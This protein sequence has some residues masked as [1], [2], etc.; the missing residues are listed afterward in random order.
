MSEGN[1]TNDLSFPISKAYGIVYGDGAR[2]VKTKR[3]DAY[4]YLKTADGKSEKGMIGVIVYN[5]RTA[6]RIFFPSA[7]KESDDG[8]DPNSG[9]CRKLARKMGPKS[10]QQRLS[11]NSAI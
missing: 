9:R 10:G 6:A 3:S 5:N 1:E 2:E 11:R 7:P 8:K 4:G